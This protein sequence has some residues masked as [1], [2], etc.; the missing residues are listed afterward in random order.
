MLLNC[1]RDPNRV[2]WRATSETKIL[3]HTR[4]PGGSMICCGWAQ[5]LSKLPI[6]CGAKAAGAGSCTAA[7]TE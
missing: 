6:I 3:S 4:Q 1:V 5:Q 2:A 7:P